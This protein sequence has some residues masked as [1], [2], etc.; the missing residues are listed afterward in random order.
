VTVFIDTERRE[1]PVL[2]V[3]PGHDKATLTAF[4]SFLQEHK[5]NPERFPEVVCDMSE[6]FL[7]AVP[8]QLPNAQITVDW[9]HIGQTFTR[10]LDEVRKVENRI[11]PLPKHLRWTVLRRGEADWLTTNQFKAMA[12]LLAQGLDTATA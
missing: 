8:K 3:T 11:K 12:E 10:A 2:F 5:G 4:R 9:F 6:A 7:S 1:K